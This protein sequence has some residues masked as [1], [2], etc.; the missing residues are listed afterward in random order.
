MFWVS[1]QVVPVVILPVRIGL[2][3]L[4]LMVELILLVTAQEDF[5]GQA[6]KVQ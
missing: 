3:V 6:V 4:R 2:N 5:L 1:D